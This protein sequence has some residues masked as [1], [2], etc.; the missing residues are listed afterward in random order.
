MTKAEGILNKGILGNEEREI[1]ALADLQSE[2]SWS[3]NCHYGDTESF[4]LSC[5]VLNKLLY[6]EEESIIFSVFTPE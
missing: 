2:A 6:F 3:I 4:K 1:P 5:F